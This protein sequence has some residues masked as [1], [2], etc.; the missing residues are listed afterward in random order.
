M[1]AADKLAAHVAEFKSEGFTVF[2]SFY[3]PGDV[4]AIRA[5]ITPEFE[6][7]FAADPSAVRAKLG[8]PL[9]GSDGGGVHNA[10][11]G[12]LLTHHLWPQLAP[13]LRAPWHRPI[14]L[15]MAERVFGPFVQ[16]DAFGITA[17]PI[18]GDHSR[19][20]AQAPQGWHRDSNI[21]DRMAQYGAGTV[22]EAGY[23]ERLKG[24][25]THAY[26]PPVGVNMLCYVRA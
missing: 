21:V 20:G 15:D 6:K 11:A 7:L 22:Y 4:D 19:R 5:V 10:V 18:A 16:L 23:R 14:L 3:S 25:A 26:K 17:Y 12:G 8:A 1:P 9:E 13:M 2:R 24:T